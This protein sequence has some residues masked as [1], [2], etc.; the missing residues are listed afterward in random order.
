MVSAS[1]PS[2]PSKKS[3]LS[4]KR[5]RMASRVAGDASSA[6]TASK[7]WSRHARSVAPAISPL[8]SASS[9]RSNAAADSTE[10]PYL[11]G[12]ARMTSAMRLNFSH[13]RA[14]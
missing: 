12:S 14:I 2:D 4:S 7:G 1:V 11:A 5:T 13:A 9:T 10:P 3:T 6:A 8:S